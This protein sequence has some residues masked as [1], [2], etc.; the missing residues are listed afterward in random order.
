LQEK[1]IRGKIIFFGMIFAAANLAEVL[2]QD[3]LQLPFWQAGRP[4]CHFGSQSAIF[5]LAQDLL[6]P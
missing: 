6:L 4:N 2:A 1:K 3:L 5:G